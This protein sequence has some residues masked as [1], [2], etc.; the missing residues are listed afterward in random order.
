MRNLSTVSQHLV[1]FESVYSIRDQHADC[2]VVYF[3][4]RAAF[5]TVPHYL[6]LMKVA[7]SG[8]VSFI[9]LLVAYWHQMQVSLVFI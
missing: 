6:L 1:Y 8:F 5:D 3:D 7:C 2:L 9:E 4:V